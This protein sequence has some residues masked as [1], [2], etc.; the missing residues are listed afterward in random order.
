M[1][2]EKTIH[3]PAPQKSEMENK[4]AEITD[5]M[6]TQFLNI[7]VE[8]MDQAGGQGNNEMSFYKSQQNYEYAKAL[9]KELDTGLEQNLRRMFGLQKENKYE[10]N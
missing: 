10:Q 3:P 7:L 5:G 1:K 9:A 8:K 4:I 6:E 2:V